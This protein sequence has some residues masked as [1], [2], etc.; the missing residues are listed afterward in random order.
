MIKGEIPTRDIVAR[1]SPAVRKYWLNWS[2]ITCSHGVLYQKFICDDKKTNN[3]QLL[4]PNILR[5]EIL[6]N[7]HDS[8]FAAHQGIHKTVDRIKEHYYWYRLS[9]DVKLHI[10]QCQV[11][12]RWKKAIPKPKAA[13]SNYCVG[14]PMDRI[15]TDVIGPLPVSKSNNRYILVVGDYFT[16][17]MEAYPIPHQQ[18]EEVAKS[19][20]TNSF[21]DSA[22]L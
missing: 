6:R 7:C 13:L 12:N 17:W 4:V 18:A 10:K 2:N 22:Y 11:C 20:F 8:V 15:G 9:E 19:L 21:R 5:K 3:L 14:Y 16:R 1:Y